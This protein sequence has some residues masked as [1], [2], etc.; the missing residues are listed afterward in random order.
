EFGCW[1]KLKKLVAPEAGPTPVRRLANLRTDSPAAAGGGQS[2]FSTLPSVGVQ[3]SHQV[4]PEIPAL[5]ARTL[6]SPRTTFITSCG[7]DARAPS[8]LLLL[9]RNGSGLTWNLEAGPAPV[10]HH[11]CQAKRG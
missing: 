4:C 6:P 1:I 11:V 8:H 10:F 7:V 5:K 9:P 2:M 3:R